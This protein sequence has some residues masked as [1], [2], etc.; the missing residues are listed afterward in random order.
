MSTIVAKIYKSISVVPT[1]YVP[2]AVYFVRSG[3]G[4]DIY[5]ADS[6]GTNVFLHN[7]KN[8]T[9]IE[10]TT[11]YTTTSTTR[12][13]IPEFVFNI[14]AGKE[15]KITLFL[16]F[17]TVATTTGVS[18]GFITPTGT[19]NVT[20]FL[21]L[22]ITQTFGATNFQG[23]IRAISSSKTLAGSFNT[24]TGVSVINSPHTGYSEILLKCITSGTF[25]V[26]FGSEVAGS[27]S[28]LNIISTMLI[29]EL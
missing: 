16:N 6:T 23:N 10:L 21:N 26:Q 8:K 9:L 5:T 15:Y 29:E 18:F 22:D 25:Q 27:T 4:V 14:E 3:N 20:G 12:A 24:S 13:N 28:Q 17:Q 7:K 11:N 2:N 19:A 1:P